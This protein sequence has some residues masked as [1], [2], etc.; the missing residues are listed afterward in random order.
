VLRGIDGPLRV[1]NTDYNGHM[2]SFAS[3]LGD[4]EVA[5]IASFVAKRWGQDKLGI[6]EKAVAD[7][8][9]EATDEGSFVGGEEIAG[10]VQGLPTQPTSTAKPETAVDPDVARLVFRGGDDVWA[11]ATCHGDSAQ[12]KETTPRLAGLPASYIEKQL[13][14]FSAGT[15]SDESMMLV[16]KSLSDDEIRELSGYFSSLRVGSTAKANL[17]GDLKRG[18]VLALKGDWSLGLPACFTCH[19]AAGFGVAP[20]FPALAAQQAPYTAAQLAAWAGGRRGSSPLGLME[21]ISKALSTADRRAVADYLA[22]LAPVPALN[23]NGTRQE[24]S[25]AGRT[26]EP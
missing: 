22:S 26:A 12:G 16:A 11:C 6:E 8:R 25:S 5:G 7:L 9:S 17:G 15:R 13:H 1:K 14:D 18:E 20:T 2:P 19:G 4:A 3:A 10:I 21:Q 23:S 24:M